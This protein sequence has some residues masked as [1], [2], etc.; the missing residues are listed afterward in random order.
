MSPPCISVGRK[1]RIWVQTH[2]AVS[3]NGPIYCTCIVLSVSLLMKKFADYH[4]FVPQ[5][6]PEIVENSRGKKYLM[7][8]DLHFTHILA[9][10]HSSLNNVKRHLLLLSLSF[11]FDGYSNRGMILIVEVKFNLF[12]EILLLTLLNSKTTYYSSSLNIII[13]LY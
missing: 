8:G 2:L 12:K 7:W 9:D 4:S 13:I 3:Q 5:L 10:I 11:Q 1:R 6:S